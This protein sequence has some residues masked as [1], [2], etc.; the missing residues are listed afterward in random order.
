MKTVHQ[1]QRRLL[2][3]R[4]HLGE[5]VFVLLLLL[6]L[7]G[8]R[9]IEVCRRRGTRRCHHRQL[10]VLVQVDRLGSHRQGLLLLVEAAECLRPL[11]ECRRGEVG[12]VSL[13][14]RAH[15]SG[16]V[17]TAGAQS[18]Q[19]GC[20]LGRLVQ[21]F[22]KLLL[23]APAPALFLIA[24]PYQADVVPVSEALKQ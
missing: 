1:A 15:R 17:D 20:V 22:E 14:H 5:R 4:I 9:V 18:G 8:L 7:S 10:V 11:G 3:L 21:D 6:L 23:G 12:R 19:Q 16:E 13:A 24:L 2:P